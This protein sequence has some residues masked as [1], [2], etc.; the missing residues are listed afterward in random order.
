M[1]AW[2]HDRPKIAC[3]MA[4][5]QWPAEEPRCDSQHSG[6]ETLPMFDNVVFFAI[7]TRSLKAPKKRL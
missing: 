4:K 7:Q 2:Y 5:T 6:R 1:L 3:R